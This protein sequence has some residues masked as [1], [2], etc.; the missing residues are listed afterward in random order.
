MLGQ[1]LVDLGL[2]GCQGRIALA[3]LALPCPLPCQLIKDLPIFQPVEILRA[4]VL[5]RLCQFIALQQQCETVILQ[6]VAVQFSE[7]GRSSASAL[8]RSAAS[9]LDRGGSTY[10]GQQRFASNA[11]VGRELLKIL[12]LLGSVRP[13][14]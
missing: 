5:S 4:Q 13:A 9:P 10:G 7:R 2:E 8:G 1:L 12:I 3:D 14:K 11:Q 6:R